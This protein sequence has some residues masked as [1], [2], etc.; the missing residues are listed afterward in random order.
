MVILIQTAIAVDILVKHLQLLTN[1]VAS[2]HHTI[3]LKVNQIH[4]MA[5]TPPNRNSPPRSMVADLVHTEE[6]SMAHRSTELLITRPTGMPL[7]ARI[8][9]IIISR[10]LRT[11]N[12][13]PMEVHNT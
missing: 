6:G 11:R 5:T 9:A 1:L 3:S 13:Q 2:R 10:K 12:H 7:Q 8:R 4:N